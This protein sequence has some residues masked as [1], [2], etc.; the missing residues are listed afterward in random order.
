MATNGPT[1]MREKALRRLLRAKRGILAATLALT[2]ALAGVAARAFPG[3]TIKSP[4]TGATTEP[5]AAGSASAPG[6]STEGASGS[7]APPEQPPQSA[8]S[9]APSGEASAAQPAP[10][11]PVVSGGS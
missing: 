6:T 1:E 11:A 2:A 9:G 5:T 3:K 8:E 4:A 10:E 7:L